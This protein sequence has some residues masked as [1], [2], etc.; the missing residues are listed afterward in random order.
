M[1]VFP[2]V[3]CSLFA[4]LQQDGYYNY[5]GIPKTAHED[6]KECQGHW[7]FS[8]TNWATP[9]TSIAEEPQALSDANKM[10]NKT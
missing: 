6:K 4:A 1:K 5:L 7:F 2:F 3:Y 10:P 8:R 9:S